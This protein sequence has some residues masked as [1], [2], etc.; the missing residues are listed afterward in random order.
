MDK[1]QKPNNSE[2]KTPSSRL[3]RI[4]VFYFALELTSV[5]DGGKPSYLF[6]HLEASLRSELFLF[7]NIYKKDDSNSS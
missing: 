1:V 7:K 3:F 6:K 4:Y 5:A 2:S